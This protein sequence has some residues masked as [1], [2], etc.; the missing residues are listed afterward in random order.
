MKRW[1]CLITNFNPVLCNAVTDRWSSCD[2]FPLDMAFKSWHL[3]T[4]Q[5][6]MGSVVCNI[7]SPYVLEFVIS[8]FFFHN[9]WHTEAHFRALSFCPKNKQIKQTWY[10]HWYKVI[11]ML[12]VWGF[13][14][15]KNYGVF[16]FLKWCVKVSLS[17][18]LVI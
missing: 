9:G 14:Y 13:L 3:L 18:G 17:C 5:F 15:F 2:L 11:L 8:L 10:L 12:K 7:P 1:Q 16:C 6:L 4:V